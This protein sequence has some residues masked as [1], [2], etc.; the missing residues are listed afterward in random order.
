MQ[1]QQNRVHVLIAEGLAVTNS[2]TRI[3]SLQPAKTCQKKKRGTSEFLTP[4]FQFPIL[5]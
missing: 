5:M 3:I 4:Y 2:I 1:L